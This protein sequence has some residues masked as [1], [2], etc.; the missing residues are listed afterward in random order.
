M[1]DERFVRELLD[2]VDSYRASVRRMRE[3]REFALQTHEELWFSEETY[4]SMIREMKSALIMR[5]RQ[6]VNGS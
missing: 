5:V 6:L 1:S 2:L 4:E 3:G